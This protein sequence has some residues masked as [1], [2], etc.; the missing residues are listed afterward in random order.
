MPTLKLPA[1]MCQAFDEELQ[2]DDRVC[3]FGED[4]GAF[5]GVRR[6]LAQMITTLVL[7]TSYV[8]VGPAVCGW[9]GCQGAAGLLLPGTAAYRRWGYITSLT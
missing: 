3:L 6:S 5:G 8:N 4:V 2:R 1:A 9:V 7:K